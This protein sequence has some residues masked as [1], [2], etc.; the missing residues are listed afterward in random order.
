MYI[1]SMGR[2]CLTKSNKLRIVTNSAPLVSNSSLLVCKK[3]WRLLV[4]CFVVTSCHGYMAS[5]L[6][7]AVS[8]V[9]RFF[10][11]VLILPY[12]RPQGMP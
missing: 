7:E 9:H 5:N 11:V 12:V 3:L 4:L 8:Q 2:L 1:A 10:V 6:E